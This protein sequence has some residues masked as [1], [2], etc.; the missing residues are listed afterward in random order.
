VTQS[1][2]PGPSIG[3]QKTHET[4]MATQT[5]R[6]T[7]LT[8]GTGGIL[9]SIQD[10]IL[11]LK[12]HT[13]MS[14]IQRVQSNIAISVMDAGTPNAHFVIIDQ[15]DGA[16]AGTFRAVLPDDLRAV[17]NYANSPEVNEGQLAEILGICISNA[18]PIKAAHGCTVMILGS[19]WSHEN[20]VDQYIP[21][22]LAGARIVSL[23]Y[24]LIPIS[25]PEY[26]D[27]G[28]V[29]AFSASLSELAMIAD[30]FITIS[31]HTRD[32]TKAFCATS[33]TRAFPVETVPLAHTLSVGAVQND[34]WP[35]QLQRLQ[36]REYVAY[37]STIEGRKN[38]AYV[39]NV[40]R[41][42]IEE[43]R[44]VPDLVFIGRS[45]WRIEGLTNLLE[46]TDFLNGRVHL[47]HGLSDT[48]LSAVYSGSLFTVF[49]SFVEGWG[50][51]V[52]ESLI[53]GKV[54][55][56]SATS[57][58]PEVGG[59][60]VDYFDPHNLEDGVRVIGRLIEDRAW[61]AERQAAIKERF[62]PRGWDSVAAEILEKLASVGAA[63]PVPMGRAAL[64]EGVV[65]RPQDLVQTSPAQA[66]FIRG[67]TR[68]LLAP[69]FFGP[70]AI[71]AWMKGRFGEIG[72][73][74]GL[75]AGTP[76]VVY[77]S[78]I[79]S[80]LFE[81]C[82][83]KACIDPWGG[84]A[85]PQPVSVPLRPHS[86]PDNIRIT[87]RVGAGGFC[88]VTLQ[89]SGDYERPQPDQRDLVI[90]L[91]KL[92]YAAAD[93]AAARIAVFENFVFTDA[94]ASTIASLT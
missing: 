26:C 49:S 37:V 47:A 27:A 5:R 2:E 65:F 56:A 93:N 73:E 42:L 43:G 94:G 45:G 41:R 66:R 40:W 19:F 7:T 18:V 12:S 11:F 32:T 84:E 61:L 64:A 69:S 71:G 24:D 17:I 9:F 48:E 52:G 6:N 50:L 60:F 10:L 82:R 21:A 3:P 79:K 88:R 16:E 83:L 34:E 92:G 81:E 13:T 53:H 80:G 87:G 36:G 70:E 90:G 8:A 75:A 35:V 4:I 20:L 59:D 54:C 28:L 86:G 72:F 63:K 67:S 39:V 51:P 78:L 55:A 85:G 33:T 25:H 22:K 14:G 46:S 15:R 91:A 1:V 62:I 76:I 89:V 44:S 23:I 30:M 74:T 68:F 38:H 58:I 57:S 77:L 31:D 29:S